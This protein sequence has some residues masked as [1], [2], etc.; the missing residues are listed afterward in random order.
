MN[1]NI[2]QRKEVSMRRFVS[3]ALFAV[4]IITAVLVTAS[5]AQDK[6][7]R[8]PIPAPV[9]VTAGRW[10]VVNGAP[11]FR[12][13]VMLLDTA[14]GDTWISCVDDDKANGWCK[15]FRSSAPTGGKT[16]ANIPETGRH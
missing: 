14:T 13:M 2:C 6:A 5:L 4:A 7:P 9:T 15:M 11:E 10:Q 8:T 12:G 1:G 3:A 16:S